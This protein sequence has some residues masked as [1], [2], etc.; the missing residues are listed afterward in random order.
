MEIAGAEEEE[1]LD[2]PDLN[3]DVKLKVLMDTRISMEHMRRHLNTA[4]N[5]VET[6]TDKLVATVHKLQ[7]SIY[8]FQ[9]SKVHFFRLQQLFHTLEM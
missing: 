4:I 5:C 6:L 1:S 9:H 7:E 3:T 8:E 2:S